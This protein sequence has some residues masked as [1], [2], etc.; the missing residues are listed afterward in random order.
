MTELSLTV[1]EPTSSLG[2]LSQVSDQQNVEVQDLR[3]R[4][5]AAAT[6]H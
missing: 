5:R 1:G 4:L 2:H 3:Q 6:Y